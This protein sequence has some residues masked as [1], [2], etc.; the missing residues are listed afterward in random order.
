MPVILSSL[1]LEMQVFSPSA[2]FDEGAD[3]GEWQSWGASPRSH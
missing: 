1:Q 3:H 2:G